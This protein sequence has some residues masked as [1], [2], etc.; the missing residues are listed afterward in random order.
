MTG[1]GA[2]REKETNAILF[3]IGSMVVGSTAVRTLTVGF[4][5]CPLSLLIHFNLI[6]ERYNEE[7]NVQQ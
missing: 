7:D 5:P 1:I 2:L 4:A 6:K 3:S